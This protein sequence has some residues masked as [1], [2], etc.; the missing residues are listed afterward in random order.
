MEAP[1]I[2]AIELEN[3][4]KTFPG[5]VKANQSITLRIKE[6]EIH[7]LLGE[8][9]A[10]KTTLMN[11]LYGLISKDTGTIKIKGA[12]VNFQSPRD[13][14]SLGIGM[15]HQHFKLIPTFTVTENV[16]LGGEPLYANVERRFEKRV[17]QTEIPPGLKGEISKFSRGIARLVTGSFDRV[18]PMDFKK[19]K[20][21]IK[22][23]AEDNAIFIDPDSKVQELS[24][25]MQQR[26]EIIKVLYREAAI[27]I[28]DE[29][30]AVLTPQEVDELFETLGRLRKAGK[31]IIL[32]THKL[33]EPMALCDRITVLR[34]GKFVGTVQKDQTTASKLA[35]MMVGRPVVFRVTKTKATPGSA[36]LSIENLQVKD[37]RGLVAIK[38]LTLEIH[39]A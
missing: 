30:T 16:V 2:Y 8:N 1:R 6:G 35:E 11:I 4:S 37:D 34:D 33:R 27:L 19:A 13:A 39:E 5:E 38:D 26:V 15:V 22:E 21:K 29:P 14:I 17:I 20:I 3:I 24:V 7:G 25:G 23:I 32:I 12:E 36:I 28:L 10:G 18:T 31:T 9:G